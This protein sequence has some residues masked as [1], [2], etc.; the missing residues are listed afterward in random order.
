VRERLPG[1]ALEA[2]GT[3]VVPCACGKGV[4][5]LNVTV[6]REG[7][8]EYSIEQ[9]SE[10]VICRSMDLAAAREARARTTAG[11]DRAREQ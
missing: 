9:I 8:L 11:T 2:V 10:C 6:R 3:E 1:M 7:L 5:T 4:I